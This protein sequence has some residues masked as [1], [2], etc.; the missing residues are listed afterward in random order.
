MAAVTSG[1]NH[2]QGRALMCQPQE[3][4]TLVSTAS[5]PLVGTLMTIG[6]QIIF[7]TVFQHAAL[8][9]SPST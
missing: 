6:K 1:E 4:K 3:Q 8:Q 2:L 7:P 5:E 9:V